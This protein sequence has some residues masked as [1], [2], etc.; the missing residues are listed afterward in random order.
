MLLIHCL[1]HQAPF[2]ISN[3]M[4]SE[5]LLL[6]TILLII[7]IFLSACK[8]Q[9]CYN[10]GV[11]TY[12]AIDKNENDTQFKLLKYTREAKIFYKKDFFIEEKSAV[13]INKNAENIET[14]RSY[15]QAYVFVDIERRT[16]YEYSSFSDTAKIL[17]FYKV[18]DD[19]VQDLGWDYLG[20]KHTKLE[21]SASKTSDTIMNG[22][23]YK[24]IKNE[25]V[26]FSPKAELRN[27]IV[28]Y[29]RCD[30]KGFPLSFETAL[31][32]QIG[33]PVMQIDFISIHNI[34]KKHITSLKMEAVDTLTT[35]EYKSVCCLGKECKEKSGKEIDFTSPTMV[36]LCF[37]S[38][39][40]VY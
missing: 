39:A 9:V 37:N 23:L 7:Q 31:S 36:W 40:I 17:K 14:W 29:L 20:T 12:K 8:A 19:K 2:I 21:E 6:I 15:I 1:G 35:K 11:V 10:C 3:L 32:K 13:E 27:I 18:P 33:C 24:R 26:S 4:E 38:S 28:G 22:I 16:F 25:T 34:N 30:K 5:K